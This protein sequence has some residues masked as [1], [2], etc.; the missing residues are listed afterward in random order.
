VNFP[1]RQVRVTADGMPRIDPFED[2]DAYGRA[3]SFL[4]EPGLADPRAIS[5]RLPGTLTYLAHD[6]RGRVI[7]AQPGPLPHPA[8]TS[9]AAPFLTAVLARDQA[10]VHV[11]PLR[12]NEVGL[13][14]L[15]VWVAWKPNP[16]T[17]PPLGLITVLKPTPRAVT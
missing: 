6:G 11:V 15:P 1:D 16:L 4:R 17:D 12:M 3:T 2:T 9:N 13:A 8:R 10:V 14:V 7:L 5:L